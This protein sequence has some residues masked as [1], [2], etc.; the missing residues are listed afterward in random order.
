MRHFLICF[1]Y[2]ICSSYALAE[3]DKKLIP[4]VAGA[5]NSAEAAVANLGPKLWLDSTKTLI[6][7]GTEVSAWND[8]A[9]T[10][11]FTQAVSANRGTK[12]FDSGKYVLQ[13]DGTQDNYTSTSTLDTIFNNNAKTIFLVNDGYLDADTYTLIRDSSNIFV[14]SGDITSNDVYLSNA[15][16]ATDT[17]TLTPV[18]WQNLLIGSHNGT[19]LEFWSIDTSSRKYQAANSGNSTSMAGTLQ[20]G[21]NAVNFF[22]GKFKEIIAFDKVLTD[23]QNNLVC[24]YL[25][26]KWNLSKN[27]KAQEFHPLP[28]VYYGLDD[29]AA[30]T[31]VTA[32][33]GAA[34][35]SLRNTDLY[36]LASGSCKVG[37][38]LDFYQDS[39]VDYVYLNSVNI[40]GDWTFCS[41]IQPDSLIGGGGGDRGYLISDG[42]E[43]IPRVFIEDSGGGLYDL[44]VNCGGSGLTFV[45]DA[46]F[47]VWH[48]ACFIFKAPQYVTLY[49]DGIQV[50]AAEQNCN[51]AY[52]TLST[53][54]IGT[55]AVGL[56]RP[57]DGRIDDY[58][59][60]TKALTAAEVAALYNSGT[61]SNPY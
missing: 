59:I 12:V 30:S 20:I 10:S 7:S 14:M 34:G 11:N 28:A 29:N 9:K 26:Q 37:R 3:L 36:S 23:S 32:T 60:F 58:R 35:T 41:W 52:G 46:A 6:M 49:W 17:L 57:W 25:V 15:D 4:I 33:F 40:S 48:H 53:L 2:I 13:M 51:A 16:G 19:Y 21:S 27:C 61:M 56:P 45:L 31:T 54:F 55:G 8:T 38:C 5:G 24:N 42:S 1:A 50:G 44:V 43:Y 47:N 22:G 39:T 18:G